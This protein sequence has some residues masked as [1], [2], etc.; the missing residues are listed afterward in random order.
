[1]KWI[2][3]QCAH[4]GLTRE[5]IPGVPE[6]PM[7]CPACKSGDMGIE[8]AEGVWG[9]IGCRKVTREVQAHRGMVQ[10]VLGSACSLSTAHLEAVLR[11][12]QDLRK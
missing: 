11:A 12:S 2:C 7:Y 9:C 6:A 4:W 5:D 3:N 8:G 10:A 1:M